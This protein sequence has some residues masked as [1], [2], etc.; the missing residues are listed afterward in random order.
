M[1]RRPRRSIKVEYE[2]KTIALADL[3][4]FG[5]ISYSVLYSR[6]KAGCRGADLLRAANTRATFKE[7]APRKSRIKELE[8]RVAALEETLTT[9][10]TAMH[11]RVSRLESK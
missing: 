5:D 4:F 8:A 7:A 9:L 3:A 1:N 10:A 2:G 6:W 11:D